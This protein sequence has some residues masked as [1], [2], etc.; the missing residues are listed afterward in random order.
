MPAWP[1]L[2]LIVGGGVVAIGALVAA[3]LGRRGQTGVDLATLGIGVLVGALAFVIGLVYTAI[4]QLR[5]RSVLPPER[6]RGPSAF[7]LLALALVVAS[8]LGAPFTADALALQSGEGQ[9][10]LL[11]SAVILVATPAGLLIVGYLL[12]F[13]PRALAAMPSLPGRDPL[14]AVLTGLGYGVLAWLGSSVVLVLVTALLSALGQPPSVGPAQRAIAMLDPWLVVLA[15]VV[16]APIAEELFFRGI[17]FNA[18]LRE[19]GRMPAYLGSAALFALIH[20]SLASL[21]PIFLL[22]LALAWVYE[23]TGTLIAPIVM[24]ATVNGISVAA[25][26]AFRFGVFDVPV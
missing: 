24:H 12:V 23:R 9:L 10:S 5:A 8:V 26:L 15:I 7:V 22:G 18:W 16:F 3:E 13:R 25:A 20:L 4:R 6:Y 11:G 17:V 2:L 21:L 1:G 14:G 19:A